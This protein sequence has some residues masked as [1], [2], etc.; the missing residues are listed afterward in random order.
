LG[1]VVSDYDREG[2]VLRVTGSLQRERG[3]GWVRQQPKTNA[4]R[5]EID[6][7]PK[8]VEL[9]ERVLRERR[10][11]RMA[12]PAWS[13]GPEYIFCNADGSPLSPNVFG[14]VFPK[15]VAAAGLPAGVTPHTLRRYLVGELFE[16]GLDPFDIAAIVGHTDPYFTRRKY[17][18]HLKPKGGARAAAAMEGAF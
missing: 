9:I 6:L 5:R 3:E 14:H 13:D 11:R 4:G 7:G 18:K 16:D 1:L 12:S 2:H 17:G 8:S 15:V 10:V